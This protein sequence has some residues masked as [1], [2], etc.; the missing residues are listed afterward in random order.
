[1][2]KKSVCAVLGILAVT[3]G[4]GAANLTYSIVDYP[5]FQIDIG[6]GLV[7]YVSGI[8]MADPITN[9]IASATFTITGNG[10]SFTVASATINSAINVVISPTEI[11]LSSAAP[12]GYLDLRG[13]TGAGAPNNMADLQWYTPANPWVVGTMDWAGYMGTVGS[14]GSGPLF[15]AGGMAPEFTYYRWVVA[16]VVPEPA[17][18]VLLA[19]GA[20]AITSRKK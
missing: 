16:T 6:T 13:S 5:A 17:T 20:L 11:I 14:K 4:A 19:I 2:K 1:M 12:D 3:V 7:D 9:T 8:I 10:N 18:M 15:A